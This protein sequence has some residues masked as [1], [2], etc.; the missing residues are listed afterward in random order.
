[1]DWGAAQQGQEDDGK[2]DSS[3]EKSVRRASFGT[4]V[5]I[6]AARR[7]RLLALALR[8]GNQEC[9]DDSNYQVDAGESTEAAKTGNHTA[10]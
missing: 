3:H 10:G 5:D 6:G 8:A 7:K 1:M 4:W 2:N 9:N